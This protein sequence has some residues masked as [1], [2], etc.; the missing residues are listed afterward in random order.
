MK[1][2]LVER[3]PEFASL[4]LSS[5]TAGELLELGGG[6]PEDSMQR[7][8]PSA[9]YAARRALSHLILGGVFERF[10]K[11]KVVLVELRADW[12]PATL[13]HLDARVAESSLGLPLKPSEYFARNGWVAPSSPRPAEVAMRHEIGIDKFIFAHRLSASRGHLARHLRM[14]TRRLP[15]CPGGRAATTPRRE[16]GRVPRHR[17]LAAVRRCPAHRP[18]TRR[19]PRL[20]GRSG[21]GPD[22]EFQQALG[23]HQAA[24]RRRPGDDRRLVDARPRADGLTAAR[25]HSSCVMGPTATARDPGCRVG[26][27]LVGTQWLR[28]A[29]GRRARA[30]DCPPTASPWPHA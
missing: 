16:R 28:F 13:A 21:P 25:W 8:G 7:F 22:R 15:R 6:V 27:P 4:D 2:V 10:P 20:A 23:L 19:H 9:L 30:A 24:R 14:A 26:T 5:L 18:P 12:V 1:E 29:A 11:L 3:N 17:P